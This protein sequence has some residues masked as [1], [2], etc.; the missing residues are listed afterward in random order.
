[1]FSFKFS[2]A[3]QPTEHRILGFMADK[4][5][6]LTDLEGAREIVARF[7]TFN[8][9]MKQPKASSEQSRKGLRWVAMKELL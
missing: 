8:G 3:P 1:V 2:L 5:R 4:R 9:S 7:G 6:K